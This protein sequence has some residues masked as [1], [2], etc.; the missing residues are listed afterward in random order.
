M[1]N[2]INKECIKLEHEIKYYQNV[3]STTHNNKQNC[4]I[5]QL[6][7]AKCEALVTEYSCCAMWKWLWCREEWDWKWRGVLSRRLE[8]RGLQDRLWSCQI[9]TCCLGTSRGGTWMILQVMMVIITTIIPIASLYKQTNKYIFYAFFWVIPRR[10][11]FMCR[12]FGTLCSI[13]IGRWLCENWIRF[14][15]VG[16]LYEKVFGSKLALPLGRGVTG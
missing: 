2:I 16:V 1:K 3:R 14:R 7:T 13:F 4:P 5:N 15:N 8:L 9:V 11:N 6:I 12:R 10:L